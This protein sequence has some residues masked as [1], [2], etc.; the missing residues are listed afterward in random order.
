[1]AWK[2]GTWKKVKWDGNLSLGY[3]CWR[4]HITPTRHVSVGI[5]DFDL[6]CF[7]HGPN[8]DESISS[9]RI[10]VAKGN[11]V[12]MITEQQAMDWVDSNKG[13]CRSPEPQLN[14]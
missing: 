13:K 14:E 10:R 2:D 8:S 1:M 4:K 12:G 11:I 5:G 9:T 7:S 6:I 3:E